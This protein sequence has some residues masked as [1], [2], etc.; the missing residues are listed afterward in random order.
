MHLL[1]PSKAVL[2]SGLTKIHKKR[3]HGHG[4]APCPLAGSSLPWG[5]PTSLTLCF[6]RASLR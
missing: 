4:V 6:A 3:G 5:I 1:K 2:G